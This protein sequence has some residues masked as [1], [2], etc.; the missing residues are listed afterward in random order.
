[1]LDRNV[2]PI[3]IPVP[4]AERTDDAFSFDETHLPGPEPVGPLGRGRLREVLE[5]G[6]AVVYW[7]VDDV[8]ATFDRLLT[9]GAREYEGP[10]DREEGFVTA[11]VVDPFGNVLGLMYS[12]H[13]LEVLG[14]AT[15]NPIDA[16]GAPSVQL[17]Q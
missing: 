15:P 6:G 3:Q 8:R 7:H 13:Y 14:S 2:Q 11:S 16:T 5:D 12:P 9:M 10:S 17:G 4:V 1:M